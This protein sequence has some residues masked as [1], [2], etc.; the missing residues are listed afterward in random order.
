MALTVE[1]GRAPVLAAFLDGERKPNR[2]G[3]TGLLAGVT[4][5]TTRE[6]LAR[7]A[8]DGVLLGLGRGQRSMNAAGVATDGRA[9]VASPPAMARRSR[10]TR[11]SR[12]TTPTVWC[13][14]AGS[15]RSPGAGPLR[16][17]AA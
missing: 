15:R 9:A 5:A 6:E 17:A 1:P 11:G 12:S 16:S 14:S 10:A 8:F 13:A 7:S 2:P 4:A 3:A